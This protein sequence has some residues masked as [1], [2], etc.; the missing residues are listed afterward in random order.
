MKQKELVTERLTL[1]RPYL[2]DVENFYAALSDG[3]IF[4]YNAWAKHD[5]ALETLAFVNNLMIRW[6]N[7]AT[8]WTVRNSDGEAMGIVCIR[9]GELGF[10]LGSKFHRKGY[11]SEAV[12]AAVAYAKECGVKKLTAVCHPENV[13]SLKILERNGF[14]VEKEIPNSFWSDDF[15][16]TDFLL[17]LSI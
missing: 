12:A 15:V 10:W 9:D 7:G 8:E 11:G 6:D 5:N 2:T 14:S 1:S 16:P 17:L 13:A 3:E 4:R